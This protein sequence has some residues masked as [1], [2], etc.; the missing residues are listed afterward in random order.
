LT[1]KT[2]VTPQTKTISHIS[3]LLITSIVKVP[4]VLI[5]TIHESLPINRVQRNN[6]MSILA[7]MSHCGKAIAAPP[8]TARAF[9]PR[10][11]RK[12]EKA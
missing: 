2:A 1:I 3:A 9:P 5:I 6:K 11:L 4:R 10:K 7:R 8:K 12:G